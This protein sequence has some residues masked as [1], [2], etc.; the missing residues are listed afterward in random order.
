MLCYVCYLNTTK[1][2]EGSVE[3]Y[4]KLKNRSK[5]YP[6]P[7]TAYKTIKTEDLHRQERMTPSAQFSQNPA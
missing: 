2:K 3:V 4:K 7:K 5:K 1:Y 6:K